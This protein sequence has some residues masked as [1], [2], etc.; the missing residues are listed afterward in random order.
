M[1]VFYYAGSLR[2]MIAYE[3]WERWKIVLYKLAVM[4]CGLIFF[5]VGFTYMN[6]AYKITKGYLP[7]VEETVKNVV[8]L[9]V[10]GNVDLFFEY[11]RRISEFDQTK[12]LR[13]V[14]QF[15]S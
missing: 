7:E 12:E 15:Q 1:F 5:Y 11:Y 8:Y 3:K 6:G 10:F 13:Y 9:Y 14:Y 2:V 4:T